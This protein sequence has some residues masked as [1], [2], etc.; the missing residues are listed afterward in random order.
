MK[1]D[2]SKPLVS[3]G[4]E[5]VLFLGLFVP[6][7]T[8]PLLVGAFL[9]LEAST[10]SRIVGGLLIMVGLIGLIMGVIRFAHHRQHSDR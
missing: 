1:V 6:A 10:G 2:K 5:W 7:M 3:G 9:L 8:L 4:A